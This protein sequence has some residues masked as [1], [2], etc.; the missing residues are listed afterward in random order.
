MEF[1]YRVSIHRHYFAICLSNVSAYEGICAEMEKIESASIGAD[2]THIAQM[3]LSV[4]YE[5]REQTATVPIVFAAMCLEAFAYDYGASNLGDA[6]VQKHLDK[7]DMI[8]KITVLSKLVTGKD[9]PAHGQ[10]YEGMV[11]L[12]KARNKLVHY[13]SKKFSMSDLNKASEY[14][15]KLNNELREEMHASI[16]TVR[17]VMKELDKLHGKEGVYEYS[18]EPTQCH[19]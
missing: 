12:G 7:L 9:F 17:A 14:H 6:Y 13:K 5:K 19:A 10:A 18:I 2:E 15:D 3:N 1:D 16:D 8:S 11:K 4:L